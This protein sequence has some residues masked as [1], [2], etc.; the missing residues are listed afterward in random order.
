MYS[1]ISGFIALLILIPLRFE[2]RAKR[3]LLASIIH[4]PRLRV[5]VSDDN[6]KPRPGADTYSLDPMF[7]PT[8]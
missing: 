5:E 6:A 3:L 1:T 7:H 8:T 4:C 2:A